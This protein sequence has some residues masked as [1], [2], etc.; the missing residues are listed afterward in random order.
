MQITV[1]LSLFGVIQRTG[2][3]LCRKFVNSTAVGVGELHG[4][5]IPGNIRG[6]LG[7]VRFDDA[8]QNRRLSILGKDLG[9]H[10]SSTTL[11][12]HTSVDGWR[13]LAHIHSSEYDER[14]DLGTVDRCSLW[15]MLLLS[16]Q[17]SIAT[18]F[19]V[20]FWS[21]SRGDRMF[22]SSRSDWQPAK[23]FIFKYF[24]L[25]TA[26]NGRSKSIGHNHQNGFLSYVLIYTTD[27][28]SG[29]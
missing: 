15:A 20:L 7:L 14:R 19:L 1:E 25:F 17:L 26:R 13:T 27:V 8:S 21:R 10:A 18:A 12:S 29:R 24:A 11:S 16:L 4:E 28:R 22:E 6:D 5:E 2:S 3:R 9:T 23:L